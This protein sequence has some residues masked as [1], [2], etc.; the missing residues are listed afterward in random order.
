MPRFC[1]GLVGVLLLCAGVVGQAQWLNHPTP[2]I[3]RTSEGRP[4]LTAPP[5]RAADGKPD[6]SGLWRVEVTPREEWV[7]ILGPAAVETRQKVQVPTMG[8]GANSVWGSNVFTGIPPSEEPLKPE[9]REIL[10]RRAAGGPEALP[11]EACMPLAFPTATLLALV[12]K[13]VQTPGL[14]LMLIEFDNTY[15]QIYTDGRALPVDPEPSWY[16]Y[17]VGKWEGD[18]FVVETNGLNDRAWIDSSGHP[19]SEAMR[20]VERYHRRDFGH[21]DVEISFNDPALYTRPFRIKVTHELQPDTDILE[22]ICTE[23]DRNRQRAR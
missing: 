18:T 19:R 8:I 21:L 16:G 3:P 6:L 17:S 14:T 15:R 9:A 12:H 11:S 10:K 22:Y 4:N 1:G 5:P 7:R 20:M 2:G 13:I 23:A